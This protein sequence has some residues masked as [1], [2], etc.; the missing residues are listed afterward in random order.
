MD[1]TNVQT[2]PDIGWHDPTPEEIFKIIDDVAQQLAAKCAHP[3]CGAPDCYEHSTGWSPA[4]YEA[5]DKHLKGPGVEAFF[6]KAKSE[7]E[8]VLDFVLLEA[9]RE[10]GA[11]KNIART[12]LGMEVEWG[13]NVPDAGLEKDFNKLLCFDAP[14]KVF[15]YTCDYHACE[16]RRQDFKS[17]IEQCLRRFSSHR[18]GDRYLIVEFYKP[19]KSQGR[20]EKR[21][22]RV[23]NGEVREDEVRNPAEGAETQACFTKGG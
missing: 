17:S 20:C 18:D 6:I 3:G 14:L 23:E 19:P 11:P 8:F 1:A 16:A 7:P 9:E 22:F 15:V 13:V 12:I 2:G 5:L 10:N 21:Q 4:I